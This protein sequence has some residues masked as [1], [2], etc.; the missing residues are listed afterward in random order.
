MAVINLKFREELFYPALMICNYLVEFYLTYL[1]KRAVVMA[2]NN[3]LSELPFGC[4]F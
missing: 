4:S 3:T 1:P 2:L